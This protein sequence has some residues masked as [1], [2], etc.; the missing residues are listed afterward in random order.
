M[1]PDGGGSS[2]RSGL[3]QKREFAAEFVEH[4]DESLRRCPISGVDLIR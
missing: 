1:T 3:P 4:G 2:C